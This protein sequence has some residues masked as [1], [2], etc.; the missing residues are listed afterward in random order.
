MFTLPNG[1]LFNTNAHAQAYENA[2]GILF[3]DAARALRAIP[4]GEVGEYET[5]VAHD[6]TRLVAR[7]STGKRSTSNWDVNDDLQRCTCSAGDR[8]QEQAPHGR[9]RL[10]LAGFLRRP[11]G[12][13]RDRPK[14][15]TKLQ[16]LGTHGERDQFNWVV[17]YYDSDRVD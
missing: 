2:F 7:A 12:Q 8:E 10:R 1:V 3:D 17:G 4:G 6:T 9:L 15:R 14:S 13:R 16:L 5:R 11:A